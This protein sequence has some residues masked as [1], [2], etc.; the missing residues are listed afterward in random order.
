MSSSYFSQVEQSFLQTYKL[1]LVA[2]VSLIKLFIVH[3]S[4][5]DILHNFIAQLIS[6]S[7]DMLLQTTIPDHISVQIHGHPNREGKSVLSL[8][9]G[10]HF[11]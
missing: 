11:Y 6:A 7:R 1:L 8:V 3:L 10:A 2:W 5:D 9:E 4:S